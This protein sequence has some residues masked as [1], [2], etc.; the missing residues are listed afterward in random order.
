MKNNCIHIRCVFQLQMKM[1]IA[2]SLC[3]CISHTLRIDH[4]L[5]KATKSDERKKAID[6]FSMVRSWDFCISNCMYI[7][8]EIG[9][10]FFVSL[11]LFAILTQLFSMQTKP[12]VRRRKNSNFFSYIFKR[13][14]SFTSS[15]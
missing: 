12:I 8:V 11:T 5:P 6:L 7:Y 9:L 4:Q 10:R 2:F 3:L 14:T 1:S 15:V 13:I